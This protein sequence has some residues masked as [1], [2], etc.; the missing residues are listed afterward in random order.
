MFF[1]H[2]WSVGLSLR[3]EDEALSGRQIVALVFDETARQMSTAPRVMHEIIA[4]QMRLIADATWALVALFFGVPASMRSA[5]RISRRYRSGVEL[6]WRGLCA[7][8]ERR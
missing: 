2:L 8:P 4:Y 7:K 6:I 3:V 5:N 1:V